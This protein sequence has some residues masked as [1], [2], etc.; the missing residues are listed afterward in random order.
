MF[1]VLLRRTCPWRKTRTHGVGQTRKLH[2]N[3]SSYLC[4][5]DQI[6][7]ECLGGVWPDFYCKN[8]QTCIWLLLDAAGER[9]VTQ[10]P[11]K[12]ERKKLDLNIAAPAL[13]VWS[14][15]V[16]GTANRHCINSSC[17]TQ[18]PPAPRATGSSEVSTAHVRALD[19]S[20]EGNLKTVFG[21]SSAT[22]RN[23]V[24]GVATASNILQYLTKQV[25][26]FS[27]F[28]SFSIIVFVGLMTF[29]VKLII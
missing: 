20:R 25:S 13:T 22:Q 9:I 2:L 3:T 6:R 8:K 12:T 24:Q 19:S 21:D 14:V 29:M 23:T 26:F 15:D 17:Q 1:C 28:P 4:N 7:G 16:V 5:N 10:S 27:W 18:D 11:P